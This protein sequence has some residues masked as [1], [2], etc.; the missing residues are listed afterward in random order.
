MAKLLRELYEERRDSEEFRE[1]QATYEQLQR[2]YDAKDPK[3]MGD[4]SYRPNLVDGM[5][6]TET[7]KEA[8]E[9]VVNQVQRVTNHFTATF[10]YPPR[11][12][13]M[14][15][16]DDKDGK[17]VLGAEDL[18]AYNNHVLT[19]SNI[20]TLHP[21]NMHW[22][23]LRGDCVYGLDWGL[24]GDWGAMGQLRRGLRLF[25]FDPGYC[26]PM[27]SPFDL[28]GVEDMLICLRVS[29]ETAKEMFGLSESQVRT[30]REL[31]RVFY[32]WTR[33]SFRVAVED[34]EVEKY[35]KEHGLGFCPFRW[36]YGD[37]SG[38][39]AQSDCR[40]IP[41]LQE[42]FNEGLLL[43]IDAIRKQ[44][45]PSWWFTNAQGMEDIEPQP[46]HASAL[47]EGSEVG[48]WEIAADP[49]IILGVMQYLEQSIQATTGV[50]PISMTGQVAKSNVT[51]TA[52]RHQVEAAEARSET[53]KALLQAAY[54]RLAEYVLLITKSQ[55]PEQVIH[56]RA[57]EQMRKMTADQIAQYVEAEAEY[58]GF[59][60]L[61]AE[62][63]VQVALQGLGRLWDMRYAVSGVLDLPG[64]TPGAMVERVRRYQLEEAKTQAEAQQVLQQAAGGGGNASQGPPGAPGGAPGGQAGPQTAPTM[65]RPQR[66]PQPSGRQLRD[67][68]AQQGGGNGRH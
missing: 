33:N 25:T 65:Q 67:L 61:P 16:L 40:G 28:G 6:G 13:V 50:S 12:M 52:V 41:K 37:P 46:G 11:V 14:P 3:G 26:Y 45:D 43:A 55:Y 59:L 27:M 36:V 58:G 32:Y 42:T 44:V 49:Q 68:L 5:P 51:G 35:S 24:L 21:R 18:T 66:P 48:R 9:I 31:T 38:K 29:P 17:D 30:M 19:R 23:S 34:V 53:R 20:A 1:R 7:Q 54:A 63:R 8:G 47:P 15:L 64:V 22:L 2:V 39:F 62:H 60:G 4:S 56:Y 57:G 10:A